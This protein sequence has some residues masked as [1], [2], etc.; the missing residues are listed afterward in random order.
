MTKE[1]I[2]LALLNKI[3]SNKAKICK[4]NL[5]TTDFIIIFKV[6]FFL[7]IIKEKNFSLR[8]KLISNIFL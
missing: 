5:N 4:K 3:N 2:L 1:Q 8:K 7:Y 6:D